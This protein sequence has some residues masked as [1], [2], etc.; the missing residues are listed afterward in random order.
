MPYSPA[1]SLP[2]YDTQPIFNGYGLGNYAGGTVA[3]NAWIGYDWG[4]G[5]ITN[6][7]TVQ[8]GYI[9]AGSTN[10]A[11]PTYQVYPTSYLV[12]NVI[13]NTWPLEPETAEQTASRLA[14]EAKWD[15]EQKQIAARARELL[16]AVLNAEQREQ[17]KKESFFDLETSSGRIYRIKPGR[18]VER[19]DPVTKKATSLFCIH[20]IV[21]VPADDIA[22]SQ[23]MWLD[24]DEEGFL[25]TA[26]ET[27]IAA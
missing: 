10:L 24:T 1:G 27:K 14:Q 20:P 11:W 16:E 6:A 19:L 25:Q 26:N 17:L 23:K 9:T 13:Y 4:Y 12:T 22:V 15:E 21:P 8:V 5:G 3:N 18:K 2:T 7:A